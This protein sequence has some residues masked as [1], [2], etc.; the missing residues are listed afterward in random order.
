MDKTRDAAVLL[1]KAEELKLVSVNE[2]IE[3]PEEEDEEDS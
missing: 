2:F 3:Q 1:A